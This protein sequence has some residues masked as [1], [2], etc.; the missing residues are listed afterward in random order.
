MVSNEEA[1]SYRQL[2]LK[3]WKIKDGQRWYPAAPVN[4]GNVESYV[5]SE[6]S[7]RFPY[8]L[9]SNLLQGLGVDS[10][11]RMHENG[12]VY[13]QSTESLNDIF[14]ISSYLAFSRNLEWIIQRN[15]PALLITVGGSLLETIQQ[16]WP[17]H[18]EHTWRSLRFWFLVGNVREDIG[19]QS[20]KSSGHSGTKHFSPGSKVYCFRGRWGDGYERITVIGKQRGSS[21][22]IT[23]VMPSKHIENWRAQL[24]YKPSVLRR[25]LG[26]SVFAAWDSKEEVEKFIEPRR[27]R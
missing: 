4:P 7:E 1:E 13:E 12:T 24:V 9:L 19:S 23:L 14:T 17:E 2:L 21:K 8:E 20:A 15:S 18:T 16:T 25:I 22:L 27:F 3:K 10:M 6:F 11:Y 5:L 26:E